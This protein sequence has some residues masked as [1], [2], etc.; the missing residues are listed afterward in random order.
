M[1]EQPV[2]VVVGVGPGLGEAYARTFAEEGWRVAVMSRTPNE[3]LAEELGG[4]AV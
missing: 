4:L 1:N 3:A 2:C